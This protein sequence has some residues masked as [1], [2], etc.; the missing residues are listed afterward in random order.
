MCDEVYA[1]RRPLNVIR[2]TMCEKVIAIHEAANAHRAPSQSQF[3]AFFPVDRG[4]RGYSAFGAIAMTLL[5]KRPQ[6]P[7][8]RSQTN[9]FRV[10][11]DR[12]LAEGAES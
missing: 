6:A 7:P 9:S 5:A 1:S 3:L 8:C 12:V 2:R 10:I 11:R 4:R